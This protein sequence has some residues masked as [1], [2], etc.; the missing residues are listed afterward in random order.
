MT[1]A[2]SGMGMGHLPVAEEAPLKDFPLSADRVRSAQEDLS[3]CQKF[4]LV[5]IVAYRVLICAID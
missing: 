4:L 3:K 2:D 1:I 5:S